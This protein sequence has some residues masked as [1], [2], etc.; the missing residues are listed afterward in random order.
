[1]KL[2]DLFESTLVEITQNPS[3]WLT[4]A[5]TE[6][7]AQIRVGFEA[8]LIVPVESALEDPEPEADYSED[9]A[10]I[11]IEEVIDFYSS[12]DFGMSRREA[13]QLRERMQSDFVQYVEDKLDDVFAEQGDRMVR[14]IASAQGSD[15]DQIDDMINSMSEEYQDLSDHVR[16]QLREQLLQEIDERDWLRSLGIRRMTDVESE[17]NVTWPI[18]ETPSRGESQAQVQEVANHVQA[19]LGQRVYASTS[20]HTAPRIA[21]AWVLEP[22][23]SISVHDEDSQTGLEL[24]TPSPPPPLPESLQYLDKV[25]AWAKSYGCETNSSTGFHMNMSLPSE[26]HANL[27]PV[28]LIL[29]LG[30][31]KIL[32]DFGRSANTYT[33]SAFA[34]LQDHIKTTEQFPVDKAMEALRAGLNRMAANIMNKPFMGKYTSVHVK[35]RYVEFRHAGG[36]YLDRLPEIK[37][38]LL[39]MAYTLSVAADAQLAKTDYAKKLYALLRGFARPKST[40]AAINLFSLYNA[41]VINSK[42]LKNSLKQMKLDATSEPADK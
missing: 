18:W 42:V 40:D 41:G 12:T 31:E 11:D 35:P 30:D 26:I 2:H 13:N 17:Y 4:W 27:D 33:Q 34:T 15:S 37:N 19:E 6:P 5:Q 7:A 14:A 23:S 1:M 24:I 3:V 39:R 25:F 16:D 29:L 8:E 36:D 20:Y 38:T 10:A 9:P 22:D 32:S 28:K 21:D